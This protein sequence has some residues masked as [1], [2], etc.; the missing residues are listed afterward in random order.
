M[1]SERPGGLMNVV[2]TGS[3]KGI[4]LGMAKEFLKNRHEVI[5]NGRNIEQMDKTLQELKTLYP[6][7]KIFACNCD[8]TDYESVSAMYDYAEEKLGNV[9]IWINN[10][11]M[12][13]NREFIWEHDV[14]KMHDLVDVNI[15][16]VLNGTRAASEKMMKKGGYIYNLEGYGS[17]GASTEKMSL[18]GMTKRAVRYYSYS[19]SR[20]VEGTKVKIGILS[21]GMVIT[22]LLLGSLPKEEKLR[23][24]YIKTYHILA[25]TVE[26]VT[27][28]LVKKMIENEDNGAKIT[29]LTKKK[30]FARFMMQM[31]KKRKVE[32]LE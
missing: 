23:K 4:G 24:R 27:E 9:D 31:F 19:A 30:A 3:T 21:P 18:Y 11:G 8:V 14:D 20:E 29:W 22:D 17:D 2:I 16:G 10:A 5:I 7:R 26:D 1:G 25:D 32:G 12:D 15:K 6:N 28:F 13:Q